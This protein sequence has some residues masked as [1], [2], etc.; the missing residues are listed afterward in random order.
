MEGSKHPSRGTGAEPPSGARGQ[1]P[2]PPEAQTIPERSE[3]GEAATSR[4]LY[5]FQEDGGTRGRDWEGAPEG[6]EGLPEG[7][8]T[9]DE[10]SPDR[11]ESATAGRS[12]SEGTEATRGR[13]N[14]SV[15]TSAVPEGA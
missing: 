11:R 3:G 14:R 7:E 10:A 9:H 5:N 1:R 6:G 15:A 2:R 8:R 12:Q 4:P 13:Q